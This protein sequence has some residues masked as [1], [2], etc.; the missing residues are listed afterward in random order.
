MPKILGGPHDYVLRINPI[1]NDLTK[2]CNPPNKKL[3]IY[4]FSKY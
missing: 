3:I 4:K 2:Y 1:K